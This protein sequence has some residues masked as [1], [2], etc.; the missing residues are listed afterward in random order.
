MLIKISYN[1]FIRLHVWENVT[2]KRNY[3]GRLIN[4]THQ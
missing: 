3:I 2:Q 1:N 4:F